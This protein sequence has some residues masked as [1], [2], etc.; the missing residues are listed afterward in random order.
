M[1]DQA[2]T[3]ADLAKLAKKLDEVADVLTDKER[4]LLLAVFKLAGEAIAAR[5]Q[6]A[7]SDGEK[8][9]GSIRA[10]AARST[11]LSDG[12]KGAFQSIGTADFNLRS[13]IEDVASGVGIGVVW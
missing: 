10:S 13:G 4:T 1:A 9:S 3:Q 5:V 6:G 7:P 11:V 2:V 12:F 8:E